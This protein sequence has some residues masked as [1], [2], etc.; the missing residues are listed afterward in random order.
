MNDWN[1]PRSVDVTLSVPRPDRCAAHAR[2][3][4]VRLLGRAGI[5]AQGPARAAPGRY[6]LQVG[7]PAVFPGVQDP[8]HDG[9]LLQVNSEGAG[10]RAATGKGLLNGVYDLAER[11][12][13]RFLMPGEAGERLPDGGS[14]G[15]RV[16]AGTWR[17][18]PRFPHRGVFGGVNVPPHNR[19]EWFRFFAKLRFNAQSH[20][21]ED[22]GLAEELGMRLEV[23]GHGMS[24]LLPRALFETKPEL[25]RMFQPEDFGGKRQPD[26]NFCTTHPASDSIVRKNFRRRIAAL[27]GVYAVHAWADDLPGGGWCLCP[28][29]RSFSAGDQS[30]LAMNMQASVVAED[31]P[32]M[33]VPV[34]AYH[35]TLYP[36]GEIAPA[37]ACFLLFAPRERCYA[38]ALDDPGCAKN[39]WHHAALRA[40]MSVFSAHGDAHT[41]E[42]YLDQILFRGLYPFF[43]DVIIGDMAAYE[44]AGI[45]SHMTL[46]V[47]GA[48]LAPD[49]NLLTFA[50]AHWNADLTADG[51]ID[52]LARALDPRAPD[53]WR[54]YLA[55]RRQAF[56]LALAVCD[57]SNEV[58][59]DYRFM[60]QIARPYGDVLV[61]NQAAASQ[62]LR[63]AAGELT[64]A[65]SGMSG[66][67]ALLA[68]TD[69]DRARFE[70]ADLQ[71]MSLHQAGLNGLARYLEDRG[72]ADLKAALETLEAADR[73]LAKAAA[74][75]R[76][77]GMPKTAYYHSFNADWTRRELRAKIETFEGALETPCTASHRAGRSSATAS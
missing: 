9:Y 50:R 68:A 18:T 28:R 38:H 42:Y 32:E 59:F 62:C 55:A 6:G 5:S 48:L 44:R 40:W 69:A 43:P 77:I 12:G 56:R 2:D 16:R 19:D 25:F 51:V 58:Y 49:Y 60:P 29:C 41:F 37:A 36:G 3:E 65:R 11:M 8:A 73:Q 26:A 30:V 17:M 70:A 27:E 14:A 53:A 61:R 1:L 67:T 52:D 63:D 23:G 15:L 33:R 71:G 39:R 34:I 75:A 4:L 20:A 22:A 54:R 13:F 57:V 47:G 7:K 74:V 76:D 10:I 45:E 24:E 21:P 66:R 35:D 64:R 72:R 31:R 46:Q